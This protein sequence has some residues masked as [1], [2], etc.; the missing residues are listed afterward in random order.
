MPLRA[1]DSQS[2]VTVINGKLQKP[3]YPLASSSSHPQTPQPSPTQ[4]TALQQQKALLLHQQQMSLLTLQQQ[5]NNPIAIQQLQHTQQALQ[6]IPSCTASGT[7]AS[8]CA[9]TSSYD[10]YRCPLYCSFTVWNCLRM[11]SYTATSTNYTRLTR[12][13]WNH[14]L[15]FSSVCPMEFF[16]S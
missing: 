11:L 16:G 1:I 12:L 6:K 8:V 13:H 14:G 4:Q 10:A 3:T 9:R 15:T 2:G 5:P 7:I